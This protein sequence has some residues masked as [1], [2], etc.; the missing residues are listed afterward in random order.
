MSAV[1][2]ALGVTRPRWFRF[3]WIPALLVLGAFAVWYFT[4]A[5]PLPDPRPTISGSTP[6]GSPVYVGVLNGETDRDLVLRD[7]EYRVTGGTAEAMIC[8]DG[9]VSVTTQADSFCTDVV[10][11]TPGITL[12]PG[13]QLIYA[14]NGSPGDTVE[15]S[16]VEVHYRD[17]LRFG[18]DQTGA[19]VVIT[20]LDAAG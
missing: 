1:G 11:A 16:A 10:E 7:L 5:A 20:I 6:S 8:R 18:S 2:S 4:H 17:G 9:G 3:A 14:V 19:R 13:D 15:V 12:G